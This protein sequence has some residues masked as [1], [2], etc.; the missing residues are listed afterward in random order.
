MALLDELKSKLRSIQPAATATAT[1]QQQ[2]LA[3]ALA[4]KSGK[5]ASGP[6]A[7]A[8]SNQAERAALAAGQSQLAA[9]QQQASTTAAQLGAQEVQQAGQLATQ[10]ASLDAQASTAAKELAAS[11][12]AAAAG[13][14]ANRQLT[15]SRI[16]ADSQMKLTDMASRYDSALKDMAA[17]RRIAVD[18][19]FAQFR[20]ENRE[21]A[22][23]KDAAQLEQL[24]FI[25][26]LSDKQYLERLDAIAR[27][28]NLADDLKFKQEA[29][30]LAFGANIDLVVKNA[31][32]TRAYN[33]SERE[34]RQAM[35]KIDLDQ[36]MQIAA[37]QIAAANNQAIFSGATSATSAGVDYYGKRTPS[38]P[39]PTKGSATGDV[40]IA[41]APKSGG[42]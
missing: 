8:A 20:S 37:N 3:D 15:E 18:D 30:R 35:A 5:A 26:A 21:L 25:S 36:A 34:W 17:E 33:A 12:A 31:E 38:T 13:L 40:A 32:W 24:A 41:T 42:G 11:N 4:A 39:P 19:V 29:A 14:Q 23:R 6:A 2:Q 1:G 27:E 10:Q 7:P 22:A 28:R 9:I 16:A